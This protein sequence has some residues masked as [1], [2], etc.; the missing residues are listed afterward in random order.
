MNDVISAALQLLKHK[1]IGLVGCGPLVA[2]LSAAL[3][4]SGASFAHIDPDAITP[5]AQELERYHALILRVDDG[6]PDGTIDKSADKPESEIVSRTAVSPWLRPEL[7]RANTRPLLLAGESSEIYLR[8]SLR[9]HAD[10]ILFV[11]FPPSELI[12]RLNRL[13]ASTGEVRRGAARSARPCLLVA[14]D[15]PDII[16]Y[17]KTLFRNA[18]VDAH[19]VSDGGAA[20]DCARRLLPDLLLL[21]LKMPV[22]NGID[23]LRHLR[24]DPGTRDIVTV[25]LTGSSSEEDVTSGVALGAAEYIVKPFTQ[26]HFVLKIKPLLRTRTAS[27]EGPGALIN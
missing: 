26:R 27:T 1:R 4:E 14:D 11:P 3:E 7:L 2:D 6:A 22:M 16:M 18:D 13:T 10:D 9:N 19:Y 12:F 21:D 8:A 17:L 24:N 20:L 25:L 23:V 5:G 15:D